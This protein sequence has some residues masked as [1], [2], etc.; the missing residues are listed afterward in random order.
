M[1]HHLSGVLDVPVS[2]FF[3]DLPERMKYPP[4][5]PEDHML[6]RESL[7]LMRHYYCI[8]DD[9][10]RSVYELVKAMGRASDM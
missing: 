2:F 5:A 10:R 4:A 3:D 7:G 9:L 8:S 6:R 1:F